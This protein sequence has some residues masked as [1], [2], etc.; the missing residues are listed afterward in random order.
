MCLNIYFVNREVC[1][2]YSSPIPS[3]AEGSGSARGEDPSLLSP[4]PPQT[5]SLAPGAGED[6]PCKGPSPTEG[7]PTGGRA[8]LSLPGSGGGGGLPHLPAAVLWD[9]GRTWASGSMG[10]TSG[11]PFLLAR[12][13][14]LSPP[15]GPT[16]L[17]L[18]PGRLAAVLPGRSRLAPQVCRGT[19]PQT[20]QTGQL[21]EMQ[22]LA[23]ID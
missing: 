17:A 20:H 11:L 10:A 23:P 22:R 5:P 14:L 15:P 18:R 4:C 16:S 12:L 13:P 2:F 3:Q 7:T 19:R 21:P 9:S 6:S 1:R 8:L